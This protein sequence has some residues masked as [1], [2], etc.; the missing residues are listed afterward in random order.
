M[1]RIAIR[2]LL[3]EDSITMYQLR[4]SDDVASVSVNPPPTFAKHEEFM[5]RT[6][7]G[8]LPM[9]HVAEVDGYFAGCCSVSPRTRSVNVMVGA[10]YR[11]MGIATLL[12]HYLQQLHHYLVAVV[13]K[14]NTA[15]LAL[16][17][18]CGFLPTP[19]TSPYRVLVWVHPEEHA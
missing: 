3:P 19:D 4:T 11:R 17:I 10:P 9:I 13:H 16:F 18:Q 15:S 1:E 8:E 6:L 2:E 14:D 5:Q 12:I 7:T